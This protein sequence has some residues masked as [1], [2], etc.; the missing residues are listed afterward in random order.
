M[1]QITGAEK[2]ILKVNAR[3]SEHGRQARC[4]IDRTPALKTV[5][6]YNPQGP[7]QSVMKAAC[8]HGHY[9]PLECDNFRVVCCSKWLSRCTDDFLGS[10]Q[11][12][13]VGVMGD[14]LPL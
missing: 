12:G 3:P 14:I 10:E 4:R 8:L 9:I 1:I 6:S 11:K 5:S 2:V 13:Q 7:Y